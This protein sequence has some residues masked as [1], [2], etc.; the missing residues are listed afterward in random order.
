MRPC[1]KQILKLMRKVFLIGVL[2]VITSCATSKITSNKAPDFNEKI[3][4]LFIM[5]KGTDSAEPFFKLFENQLSNFLNIKEIESKTHYF[6]PL[7]LE[8]ENDVNEKISDYKPNLIMVINQTESR[9][10]MNSNGF[11]WGFGP[12]NIGG[13]FDIKIFQPNSKNL[14]WRGNLTADGQ[15]GLETSAIKASDKLIKKLIEDGLL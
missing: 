4:K 14:I 6:D 11:G 15:F 1:S 7:S 9:Q 3:T 5:I 10:I 12:T 8:S 2:L 13:T